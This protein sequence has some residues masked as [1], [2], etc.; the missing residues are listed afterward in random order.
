[1]TDKVKFW[2]SDTHYTNP[3]GSYE[4]PWCLNLEGK[5][6]LYTATTA[7]NGTEP[8]PGAFKKFPD[9]RELCVAP[10]SAIEEIA[11]TA[12]PTA[13]ENTLALISDRPPSQVGSINSEESHEEESAAE[14]LEKLKKD[15]G[16]EL[17]GW[18]SLLILAALAY[19][20][21]WWVETNYIDPAGWD[22]HTVQSTITAQSNWMVGESK[23]CMSIPLEIQIARAVGKESGYAFF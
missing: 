14:L 22:S 17:P 21:W 20:G 19:G 12:I 1:M 2:Y 16:K 11:K 13:R 7:S 10:W 6:Y 23:T 15:E 18:L 8:F 4:A 9:Y 5:Q 3:P